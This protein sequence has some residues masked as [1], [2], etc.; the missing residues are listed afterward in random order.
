[1]TLVVGILCTDGIVMAADSASSILAA[2]VKELTDRKIVACQ[3]QHLLFGASGHVGFIDKIH[4][5]ISKITSQTKDLEKFRKEL[6]QK[7][8]EEHRESRKNHVPF[9]QQPNDKPPQAD[10]IVAGYLDKKPFLYNF[11]VDATDSDCTLSKFAAVGSGTPFAHT[12]FL[13]HR[14][15]LLNI[16]LD[17][18]KIIANRIICDAISVTAYGLALPVHVYYMDTQAHIKMADSAEM[19]QINITCEAWRRMESDALGN[20][21]TQMKTPTITVANVDGLPSMQEKKA[22]K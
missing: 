1:M 6:Q 3:Q 10:C 12:L 19:S 16:N 9:P 4:S 20:A 7:F 18:G 2:N 14:S 21:L 13:P 22:D 11:D 8:A 5:S 17:A 15:N